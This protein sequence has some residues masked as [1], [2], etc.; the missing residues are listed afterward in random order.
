MEVET[1]EIWLWNCLQTWYKQ[2]EQWKFNSLSKKKNLISKSN[3]PTNVYGNQ[4]I[5]QKSNSPSIR[6]IRKTIF[7]NRKTFITSY[8]IK[9]NDIISIIK[10][11][12]HPKRVN[13]VFIPDSDLYEVFKETVLKYFSH[14]MQYLFRWHYWW[15]L[16]IQYY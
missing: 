3:V 6:I 4:I 13:A 1:G 12:F 5:I 16:S 8:S 15:K 2:W 9:E 7:K 14:K 10:N 11:Y